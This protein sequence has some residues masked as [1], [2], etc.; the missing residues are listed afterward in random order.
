[1]TPSPVPQPVPYTAAQQTCGCGINAG[2]GCT[3]SIRLHRKQLPSSGGGGIIAGPLDDSTRWCLFTL[4]R[5]TCD[6]KT[7]NPHVGYVGICQSRITLSPCPPKPRVK[8]KPI[9]Q[10]PHHHNPSPSPLPNT[11]Q[12]QGAIPN[13]GYRP[14][15][16]PHNNQKKK[17]FELKNQ[18][19]NMARV[20]KPLTITKKQ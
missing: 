5:L 20:P 16:P 13:G 10:Q 2:G 18:T 8:P 6:Q 4:Q 19:V 14:L 11:T 9:P 1:M 3:V 12:I 17:Q 7:Q 15:K